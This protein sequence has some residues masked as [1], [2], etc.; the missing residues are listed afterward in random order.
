MKCTFVFTVNCY[1]VNKLTDKSYK[2]PLLV[3]DLPL[4]LSNVLTFETFFFFFFFGMLG[5]T[6]NLSGLELKAKSNVGKEVIVEESSLQTLYFGEN[7]IRI[8]RRV[9]AV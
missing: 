2:V 1:I 5:N 6:F 3:R 4:C 9:I 8:T 7:L